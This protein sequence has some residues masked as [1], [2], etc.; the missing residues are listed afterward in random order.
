MQLQTILNRVTNYK[1]FV[2]GRV[3][4]GGD[5]DQLTLHVEMEARKNGRAICSGCG[6]RRPGYDHLPQ[7][8]WCFVPLWQIAVIL[9]YAPRRVDCPKCGVIIE[10][11]PWGDGKSQ[12]THEYRLFLARW[13]RRLSWQEVA[14]VFHTSWDSVYRAVKDV[15]FWGLLHR[16]ES[17]VEAIGIDEIQYQRGHKYLTL[18]YQIDEHCRRLLWIGHERKEETLQKFFDLYG[19][20]MLPTLKYV[21]SDMWKGYVKVIRERAGDAVHILDRYH[22]MARLNKAIDEVRAGEA[23]RMKEDGHEPILKHSRWCLLK[24][25]TNLTVNQVLKLKDLLKY[26]FAAIR[27]YL[28]RE[29]FQ[30]FW[31][32]QSS[33]WAGKFLDQWIA[34]TMRSRLEPMKR[35]AKT[36][37]RHRQL[38][39]NWFHAKGQISAGIVEGFNNKAKLTMRKSYGFRTDDGIEIALYHSLAELPEPEFTHEFC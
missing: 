11:V 27:A 29:D 10:R 28:L 7:R 39:L 20:G 1:P 35:E 31:Q 17:G 4:W 2:F 12:Q 34:R 18:V 8:A 15:V 21:C 26:N 14:N 30:R 32:Y 37:R 38:L 6:K 19:T 22:I 24:S 5:D 16:D 36:L 9:V 25:P 13:A 23:R 33:T 3:S